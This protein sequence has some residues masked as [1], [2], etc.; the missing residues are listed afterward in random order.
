MMRNRAFG[1]LCALA[2][3]TSCLPAL[4]YELS[5]EPLPLEAGS[6]LIAHLSSTLLPYYNFTCWDG[7]L[8]FL[9]PQGVN[10][11]TFQIH[12]WSEDYVE[13]HAMPLDA[14]VSLGTIAVGVV[15]VQ[16]Y[17][18]VGNPIPGLPYCSSTP[19]LTFPVGQNIFQDSFE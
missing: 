7:P 2:G 8:P 17:G 12:V 1:I 16:L 6:D 10:G 4:G 18:C 3:A 5:V 14:R 9:S 19:F 11:D 13:C 15:S